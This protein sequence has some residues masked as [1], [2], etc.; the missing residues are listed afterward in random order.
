MTIPLSLPPDWLIFSVM[1]YFLIGEVGY[2]LLLNTLDI[3]FSTTVSRLG[4]ILEMH[5]SN[6]FC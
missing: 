5:F 6:C 2:T 4:F 3:T 1:E